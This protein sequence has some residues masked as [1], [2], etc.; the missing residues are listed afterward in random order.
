VRVCVFFLGGASSMW[1]ALV[2]DCS[3]TLYSLTGPNVIG[4]SYLLPNSLLR[5]S[6]TTGA[7]TVL[8]N[9]AATGVNNHAAAF[10]NRTHLAHF[11]GTTTPKMELLDVGRL[12]TGRC[13]A[14]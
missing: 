3:G 5:V 12:A 1:P 2:F 11:Y 10:I 6:P 9:F 4:E 8:C 13:A 7:A 14:R